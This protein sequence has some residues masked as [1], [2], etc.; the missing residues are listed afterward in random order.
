MVL[1]ELQLRRPDFAPS[2][3]LDYGTGTASA[4]WAVETVW[5]STVNS[6]S[7]VLHVNSTKGDDAECTTPPR[8]YV[9]IDL[10]L[11]ML[12]IAANILETAEKQHIPCANVTPQRD[13]KLDDSSVKELPCTASPTGEFQEPQPAELEQQCTEVP[14]NVTF[15]QT[16]PVPTAGEPAYDLVT[17][18]FSLCEIKSA[19]LRRSTLLELWRNTSDYLVLIE[20]GNI[21]GFSLMQEARD[22]LIGATA[23]DNDDGVIVAPCTHMLSCPRADVA[24]SSDGSAAMKPCHFPIRAEYPQTQRFGPTETKSGIRAEKISYLI[25]ARKRPQHASGHVGRVV[26]AMQHRSGHLSMQVCTTEATLPLAAA[27]RPHGRNARDGDGDAVAASAT[28]ASSGGAWQSTRPRARG[29]GSTRRHEDDSSV[30]R[31]VTVPRSGGKDAWRDCKT[32]QWGDVVPLD[33]P[34]L[35]VAQPQG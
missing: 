12:E 28:C 9:G 23:G 22:T 30:I 3:V 29:A 19:K 4:I 15:R 35:I 5:P 2:N 11:P 20:S 17:S 24:T 27:T 33:Y 10:S 14:K 1:K 32:R 21:Q 26:G 18:A 25:F 13:V 8:A 7:T 34:K 6:T 31:V 16:I